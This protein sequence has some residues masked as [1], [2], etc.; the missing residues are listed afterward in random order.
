M[1][2]PNSAPATL[3]DL[4]RLI[5][6]ILPYADYEVTFMGL[7]SQPALQQLFHSSDDTNRLLA[8]GARPALADQHLAP[9]VDRVATLFDE[10]IEADS[11]GRQIVVEPGIM[12]F[13]GGPSPLNLTMFT[14]KLIVASAILGARTVVEVVDASMRGVPIRY[15]E[16]VA[17]IGLSIDQQPLQLSDTTTISGPLRTMTETPSLFPIVTE[18]QSPA[19]LLGRIVLSIQYEARAA[20]RLADG[21]RSRPPSRTPVN[22]TLSEFTW[23]DLCKALSLTCD[24]HIDQLGRWASYGDLDVFRWSSGSG[25][26]STGKSRWASDATVGPTDWALAVK[27]LNRLTRSRTKNLPVYQ[28]TERWWSSKRDQNI[29]DQFGDLRTALERLFAPRR[30]SNIRL[31]VANS[32][33]E[34][35]GNNDADQDEYRNIL[36]DAYR[37]ASDAVHQGNVKPTDENMRV[38]TQAQAL[39]REGILQQLEETE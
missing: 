11:D 28:A 20:P 30:G 22:D 7:M 2:T 5:N 33:A 34:L 37:I 17:L 8:G 35:L 27:I 16:N 31:R 39:C 18:D 21:L 38:L 23:D 32:G 36:L 15:L 4:V 26:W 1:T 14:K 13:F 3:A 6:A 12:G 19:D 29:V 10:R 24:A 9:V 25:P